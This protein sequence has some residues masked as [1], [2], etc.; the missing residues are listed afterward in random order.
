MYNNGVIRP[1]TG[2]YGHD[3]FKHIALWFYGRQQTNS[4]G[5]VDGI[6]VFY[7]VFYSGGSCDERPLLACPCMAIARN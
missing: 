3:I 2:F 4:T 5:F 1:H 7:K 6:N